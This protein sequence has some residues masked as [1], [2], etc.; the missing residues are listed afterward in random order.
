[1][2]LEVPSTPSVLSVGAFPLVST[3]AQL[4]D[5]LGLPVSPLLLDFGGLGVSLTWVAGGPD[6]SLSFMVL[7]TKS[8]VISGFM[9]SWMKPRGGW[10]SS[11]VMALWVGT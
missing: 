4:S 5:G 7:R 9:A 6:M 8:A 11:G 3:S 1:M 10:F 2:H